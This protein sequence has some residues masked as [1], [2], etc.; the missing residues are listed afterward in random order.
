M[1]WI[2]ATALALLFNV[3]WM[4]SAHK[5]KTSTLFSALATGFCLAAFVVTILE[6]CKK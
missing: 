4:A 1:F 6:Y 5:K 3:K 2:I